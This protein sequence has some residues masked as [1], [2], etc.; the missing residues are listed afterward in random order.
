[1]ERIYDYRMLRFARNDQTVLPGFSAEEYVFYSNASDREIADL[2]DELEAVRHATIMLLN[3]LTDEALLRFGIMNDHPV[4]VRALAYH[5]AAHEL[6]HIEIIKGR[7][8][9]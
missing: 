6:H 8:L 2:L 5:F 3:G 4:S 9:K 7:Y 1:M